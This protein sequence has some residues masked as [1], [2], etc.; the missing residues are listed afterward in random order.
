VPSIAPQVET[1]AVFQRTPAWVMPKRDRVYSERVRS[2][3]ARHPAALRAS[4]LVQYWL[5]EVFGP[6]VYLDSPR[7]SGIAERQCLRYLEQAVADPAIRAKLTPSFQFGCKRILISDDYWQSF[8]REN[9]ELVTDPIEEL[10]R[11]GVRTKDGRV[12]ELDA[13]VFATGFALN[14]ATAPFPVTGL[15]GRT[16]DDVWKDGAVAYKGL[17]VH[18]FPNWFVLMGPNT[19]PGHTSVLVFSEAQISHAIGAIQK[20]RDENWKSVDVRQDVQDRYNAGLERRM[21]HMVW[22]SGCKSWYLSPDGKN[23]SLYPGPAA[24]YVVRAERFRP[25]DYTISRF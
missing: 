7:L 25:S 8:N 23:H 16:L 6:M 13:I 2:F 1:L 3:L 15:G 18:G 24:E 9:V 4:R 20:L 14:I 10:V 5:T 17:A 12:L 19:G 22:S 21:E 11:E